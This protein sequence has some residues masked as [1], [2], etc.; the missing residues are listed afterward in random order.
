[1]GVGTELM[2][3]LPSRTMKFIVIKPPIMRNRPISNKNLARISS[4]MVFLLATLKIEYEKTINPQKIANK[5]IHIN[6]A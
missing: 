5:I 2:V 1:M 3:V 4:L 6:I